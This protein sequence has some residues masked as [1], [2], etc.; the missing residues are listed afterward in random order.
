[1]YRARVDLPILF[2]QHYKTKMCRLLILV[3]ILGGKWVPWPMCFKLV[4]LFQSGCDEESPVALRVWLIWEHVARC[5][6]RTREAWKMAS[7]MPDDLSHVDVM[8][9]PK[10][11]YRNMVMSQRFLLKGTE[12]VEGE[13]GG[14]GLIVGSQEEGGCGWRRAP[15]CRWRVDALTRGRREEPGGAPLSNFKKKRPKDKGNSRA[16]TKCWH[17]VIFLE[18]QSI[19][20]RFKPRRRLLFVSWE[21]GA[22]CGAGVLTPAVT[23]A[24]LGR[25]SPTR[26][27]ALCPWPG[28]GPGR[29]ARPHLS[30]SAPE[31]V[32]CWRASDQQ[33][34]AL[35]M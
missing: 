32:R 28:R 23:L 29:R 30:C 17:S 12:V 20:S 13:S 3:L 10:C 21:S 35:F 1:M 27:G 33:C 11:L 2:E 5:A 24:D 7:S 6:A 8:Y 22:S 14:G 4:K 19:F 25:P 34:P 18:K 26:P 16:N 9:S 15:S 31:H